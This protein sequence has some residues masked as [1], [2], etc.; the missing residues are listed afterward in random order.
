VGPQ[1]AKQAISVSAAD[2]LLVIRGLRESWFS[3]I[4]GSTPVENVLEKYNNLKGPSR[5][6]L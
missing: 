3:K 2:R 5:S 4:K 6:F 1:T